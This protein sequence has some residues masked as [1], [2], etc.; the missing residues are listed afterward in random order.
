[1]QTEAHLYDGSSRFIIIII[2]I[3]FYLIKA[4]PNYICDI[5]MIWMRRA[6]LPRFLRPQTRF[7]LPGLSYYANRCP[8]VVNI[9]A[10]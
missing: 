6:C 1:M 8:V 2:I 5:Y 4:F 7:Q 3:A 9:D 10:V